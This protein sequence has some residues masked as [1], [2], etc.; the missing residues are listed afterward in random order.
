MTTVPR[1]GKRF[2]SER[3]ASTATWSAAFSSP[4]PRSR[5]AATAARS[6]TRTSSRV[7]IRS[8]PEAA[9][10]CWFILFSS[11]SCFAPPRRF[12]WSFGKAC[13]QPQALRGS[14][15]AFD[16]DYLRLLAQ[17]TILRDFRNRPAHRSLRRLVGHEDHGL[18]IRSA[19]KLALL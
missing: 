15:R 2:S 8:S 12:V 1:I 10:L 13:P 14:G 9:L 3:I 4:R 17:V 19:S 11:S 5:A 7:K 18:L 6:V 16:P